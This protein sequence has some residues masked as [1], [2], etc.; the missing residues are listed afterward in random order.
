MPPKV[1]YTGND[2]GRPDRGCIE[3]WARYRIRTKGCL[4]VPM[5]RQHEDVSQE[6]NGQT[7]KVAHECNR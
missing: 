5:G 2:D 4:L 1:V 7:V 6:L 3:Y